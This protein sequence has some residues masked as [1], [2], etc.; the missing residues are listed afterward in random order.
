V[1]AVLVELGIEADAE[2]DRLLEVW[3]KAD[4]L[5]APARTR[6]KNEARRAEGGVVLV[7]AMTGEGLDALM[8]EIEKRLNRRRNTVEI[9]VKPE[10]GSL[11]NWIYENCEVVQRSD[12]GEGMTALRIRIAPEKRHLLLRLAGPARLK[13]AAE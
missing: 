10:E 13:L 6:I 12:L 9:A 7:S 3:N 11:S 2:P 5:D 4:L 1:H 8:I